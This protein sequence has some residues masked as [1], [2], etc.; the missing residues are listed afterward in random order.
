MNRQTDEDLVRT[1]EGDRQRVCG[2]GTDRVLVGKGGTERNCVGVE[3]E[4]TE[5]E[6]V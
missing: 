5:Y 3:Q 1:W 4:L 2:L 6:W